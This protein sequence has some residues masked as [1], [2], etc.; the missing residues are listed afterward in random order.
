MEC[1]YN[2][3]LNKFAPEWAINRRAAG[4]VQERDSEG[5]ALAL[6]NG[7]SAATFDETPSFGRSKRTSLWSSADKADPPAEWL[8][9]P[10][11]LN[12]VSG[13]STMGIP[14]ELEPGHRSPSLSLCFLMGL[15]LKRFPQKVHSYRV[16]GTFGTPGTPGR[17]GCRTKITSP[18]P[19]I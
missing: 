15:E 19:G 5:L 12:T 2:S 6:Q 18:M 10:Q 9:G 14:R 8:R 13:Q 3:G 16:P 11:Q 7:V 4:V 1:K 17:R